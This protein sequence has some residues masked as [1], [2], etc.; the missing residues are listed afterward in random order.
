MCKLVLNPCTQRKSIYVQAIPLLTYSYPYFKIGVIQS[1]AQIG[2]M[3][4][5]KA[6]IG[7]M[8]QSKKQIGPMTHDPKLSENEIGGKAL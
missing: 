2:P 5:N 1:K 7:L 8:I 3:I 6:Q 4:R